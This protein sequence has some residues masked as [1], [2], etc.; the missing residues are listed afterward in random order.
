MDEIKEDTPSQ[1]KI[2]KVHSVDIEMAMG[3]KFKW[4]EAT[5]KTTSF[6]PS[7]E[8]GYTH[9][10]VPRYYG[11]KYQKDPNQSLA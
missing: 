11:P 2:N 6:K 7:S 10:V 1:S 8:Q 5:F 4:T 3:D 9:H